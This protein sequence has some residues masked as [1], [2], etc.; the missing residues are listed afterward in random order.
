M[1]KIKLQ[2]NNGWQ[3]TQNELTCNQQAIKEVF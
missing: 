2:G 3:H 1:I